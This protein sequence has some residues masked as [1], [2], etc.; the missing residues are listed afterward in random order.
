MIASNVGRF[1]SVQHFIKTPIF[2]AFLTL[3]DNIEI[4]IP[5]NQNLDT[6]NSGKNH[7][8]KG[9]KKSPSHHRPASLAKSF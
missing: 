6:I 5:K 8:M 2:G 3:L 9:Q 7:L 1:V 4:T